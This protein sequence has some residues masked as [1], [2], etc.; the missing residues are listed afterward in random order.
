[1][2]AGESYRHAYRSVRTRGVDGAPFRARFTG[3]PFPQGFSPAIAPLRAV[4]CAHLPA[5]CPGLAYDYHQ[6]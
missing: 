4:L 6:D 5:H 1:M 3:I 2:G